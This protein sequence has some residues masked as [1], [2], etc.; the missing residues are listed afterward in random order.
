[1]E[2]LK[3]LI[4]LLCDREEIREGSVLHRGSILKVNIYGESGTY[5][6]LLNEIGGFSSVEGGDSYTFA[7]KNDE[8]LTLTTFCEGDV[9]FEVC[10]NLEVYQEKVKEY[11]EFYT[12]L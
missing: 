11:T 8:L 4:T 5:Y 10:E 2:Q 12:N 9:N 7:L 3:K 6:K 1:M